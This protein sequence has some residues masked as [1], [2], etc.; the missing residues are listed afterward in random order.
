[1]YQ[2]QVEGVRE[3]VADLRTEAEP[4]S[5]NILLKL[6]ARVVVSVAAVG[7]EPSAR[8]EIERFDCSV[9]GSLG[10]CCVEQQQKREAA[11]QR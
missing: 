11:K 7:I 6:V 9:R 10:A 4:N 2:P 1:M 5:L 3:M 8:F